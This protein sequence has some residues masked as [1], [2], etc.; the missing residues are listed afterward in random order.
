MLYLASP[1]SRPVPLLPRRPRARAAGEPA[2]SWRRVRL[3][4]LIAKPTSLPLALRGRPS[5]DFQAWPLR[6]VRRPPPRRL[7]STFLRRASGP[8]LVQRFLVPPNCASRIGNPSRVEMS[9]RREPPCG[10]KFPNA[11][12][13]L[14]GGFIEFSENCAACTYVPWPFGLL[15]H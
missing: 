15:S 5:E 3:G 2:L 8:S 1:P 12:L 6:I 14:Q 4:Y 10:W 9:R 11:P 7:C 13:H